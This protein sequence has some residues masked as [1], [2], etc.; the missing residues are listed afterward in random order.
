MNKLWVY[1]DSFAAAQSNYNPD[2]NL[3]PWFRQ[4]GD[5]LELDKVMNRAKNGCDNLY[6][7]NCIMNDA[8]DYGENDYIIVVL[9]DP[10]RFWVFENY[11]ELSNWYAVDRFWDRCKKYASS[12]EI[13]AAQ[14]FTKYLYSQAHGNTIHE[15]TRMLALNIHP[16][17]RVLQAFFPI[18]GV[19]GSLLEV[20]R[21]EHVGSTIEEKFENSAKQEFEGMGDIRQNHLSNPNHKI[22]AEKMFKWFT[23]PNYLLDLTTDFEKDFLT[24]KS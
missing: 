5:L 20:S 3:V 8:P 17:V 23:D 22:L 18:P 10:N 2:I 15:L 21:D 9:T 14:G 13:K 19:N 24:F 1:G 12:N 6:I 16:N 11:P 7:A 4:L